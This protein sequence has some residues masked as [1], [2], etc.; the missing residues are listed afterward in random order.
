LKRGLVAVGE[1]VDCDNI[2]AGVQQRH[3][4]MGPDVAGASGQEDH[5]EHFPSSSNR[6]PRDGRPGAGYAPDP[7]FTGRQPKSGL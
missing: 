3:A 5:V 7:P 4:D 1:I 2:E 6:L